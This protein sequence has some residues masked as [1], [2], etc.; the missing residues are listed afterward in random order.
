MNI[1]F[2]N[3]NPCLKDNEFEESIRIIKEGLK[4][5]HNIRYK[6]VR[7]LNIRKCVGCLRCWTFSPGRCFLKDDME[8][9]YSQYVQADLVIFAFPVLSGFT[10]VPLK[11]VQDR[12]CPLIHPYAH[13]VGN[14]FHHQPRY[15]RNPD[16]GLLL[17]DCQ[18]EMEQ[19]IIENVYKRNALGFSSKYAFTIN[20]SA[21]T[22]EILHEINNY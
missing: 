14:E 1:L 16:Y 21:R 17:G 3:G 8:L 10:S 19:E 9:I 22:E 11:R 6:V 5:D 15:S 4:P 2:L 18:S 12:F 7:E 13:L 20:F